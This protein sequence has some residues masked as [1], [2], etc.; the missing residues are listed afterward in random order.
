MKNGRKVFVEYLTELMEKDNKVV[1][2]LGDVGFSFLEPLMKTYPKR[3]IN[4]GIAEQNMMGVAV[5]F[6][7]EGWKPYVYTMANFIFSR[8]HEFVRNDICYQNKN[9]KLFGVSGSA[10]YAF[11]GF[12]HNFTEDEDIRTLKEFP[13][14]NVYK[15][16]KEEEI[17]DFMLKEYERVGPSYMRL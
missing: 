3:V 12:S 5:G 11:L 14:I 7:I 2:L 9:V 10:A 13:N 4:C 17:S 6:A 8:P 16:T 1:L 15:P